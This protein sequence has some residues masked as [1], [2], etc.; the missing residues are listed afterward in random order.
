MFK[1]KKIKFIILPTTVLSASLAITTISYKN[2]NSNID[3]KNIETILSDL[4]YN[5]EYVSKVDYKKGNLIFEKLKNNKGVNNLIHS[6]SFNLDKDELIDELYKLK[7][8]EEE[9]RFLIYKI[10]SFLSSTKNDSQK[11]A[12]ITYIQKQNVFKEEEKLMNCVE[13]VDENLNKIQGSGYHHSYSLDYF[14]DDDIS[15][16]HWT[17]RD[18]FQYFFYKNKD[19]IEKNLT[20]FLAAN[21]NQM[22][23]M[24]N[25]DTQSVF[26][27]NF[28]SLSM[29]KKISVDL[30]AITKS[31]IQINKMISKSKTANAIKDLI[32]MQIKTLYPSFG[33]NSNAISSK[34]LN[35]K[36]FSFINKS[37][38]MSI[39]ELKA[40]AIHSLNVITLAW[41]SAMIINSLRTAA[42]NH[43]LDS[44]T[45]YDIT[46]NVIKIV[47]SVLVLGA[48]STG[49][50]LPIAI[51]LDL[52][53]DIFDAAIKTV[54]LGNGY[55]I[56]ENF[57]D[58]GLNDWDFQMKNNEETMYKIAF[59]FSDNFKKG[60]VWKVTDGWFSY[61]ELY[62]APTNEYIEDSI[63]EPS[64][65]SFKHLSAGT[66]FNFGN[67]IKEISK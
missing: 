27:I 53:Y 56:Y 24:K 22:Q 16:I 9:I 36:A 54:K 33:S 48:A 41:N 28:P 12:T 46:G 65:S 21:L 7:L 55:T 6:L 62:I 49:V 31:I 58:H 3:K 61:P 42:N 57:N 51:A 39:N 20:E 43:N 2:D 66:S 37:S 17:N 11:S 25:D 63:E 10:S 35:S 30:R 29:N 4:K 44:K 5:N 32:I 47:K 23:E 60:I 45:V 1:N 50:G 26:T 67:K 52:A 19:Y 13:I 40:K 15:Y 14:F 8:N 34:I 64:P 59:N 18:I 38:N